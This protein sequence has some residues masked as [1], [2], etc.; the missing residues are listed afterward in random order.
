MGMSIIRADNGASSGLA[1]VKFVSNSDGTLVLSTANN[2]NALTIDA[3]QF[4]SATSNGLNKGEIPAEQFY[5]LNS[6][7]VGLAATSAQNALNV[8]VTLVGNTVY[9]FECLFAMQ[10]TAGTSSQVMQWGFG[11]TAVANNILYALARYFQATSSFTATGIS[12]IG[13]FVQTT[14][15]ITTMTAS[16]SATNSHGYYFKGIVSIGTGG[17]FIPQYTTTASTG[18]YTMQAGS[19]FK[20]SPI[21]AAGANI[22]IGSWA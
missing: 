11:G 6:N 10:K 2:V 12:S 21:S 14:S 5:R 7:L 17:T 1:G 3:S 9:Q 19:F 13:A 15:P 22:N 20:I 18:P 8:G 4:L 16:V